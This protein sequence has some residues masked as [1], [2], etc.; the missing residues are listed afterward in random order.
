V[1]ST[2]AAI[3][4]LLP[5]RIPIAQTRG[6]GELDL[7][8]KMKAAG[9]EKQGAAWDVPIIDERDDSHYVVKVGADSKRTGFR[10]DNRAS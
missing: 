10:T 5:T 8:T 6:I 3:W 7:R 4:R 9:Y 1:V 2:L